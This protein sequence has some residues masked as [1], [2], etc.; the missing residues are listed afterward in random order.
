[1]F[2]RYG[3]I[4]DARARLTR[5]YIEVA[6]NVAV[7]P[8]SGASQAR[9]KLT[10]ALR[11]DAEVCCR[12]VAPTIVR[13][14]QEAGLRVTLRE[15]G[16]HRE[17]LLN[18]CPILSSRALASERGFGELARTLVVAA[19]PRVLVG[20]LG[21]GATLAGVLSWADPGS[22]VLVVE[23]L[24]TV[25]ALM[26]GEYGHSSSGMLEDPRV[27]VIQDDVR[28]VIHRERDLSVIL[29]DVDNGPNWASFRTNAA[30]YASDG[31]AA[32]R[33]ALHPNGAM[34]V[35]SG[36]PADDFLG[37]L[38]RGGFFPSVVPLREKGLVR[39]RAVRRAA[40]VPDDRGEG[41]SV[42]RTRPHLRLW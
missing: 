25:V 42:R 33:E 8:H 15:L 16:T 23:K 29:L 20:G 11:D 35:W 41:R 18:Q 4:P 31:L 5:Y 14:F 32:I 28:T 36:Y 13:S 19:R 10:K 1:M 39:A 24:A 26:R 22:E 34:M 7:L 17:L 37:R 30:L 12:A 21:F 9:L 38:R 2:A 3:C 40:S 27:R 6:D